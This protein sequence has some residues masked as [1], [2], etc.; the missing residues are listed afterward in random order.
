MGRYKKQRN[1]VEEVDCTL[2]KP[3]LIGRR[4]IPE[5]ELMMDEITAIHLAD[6]EWWDMKPSAE[7][8]WISA[9]TFCRVLESGRKKLW[10]AILN[11]YAIKICSCK[12]KKKN[13]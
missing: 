12:S 9:P 8:M 5:V 3:V 11:W 10:T 13:T 2:F 1:I 6:V 7:K 4:K